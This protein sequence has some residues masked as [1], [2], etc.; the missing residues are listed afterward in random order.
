MA[1]WLGTHGLAIVAIFLFVAI[2]APL[3]A[4]Q[5]PYD[6]ANLSLS[7]ARRPPGYV[8]EGGYTHWLGTD[9]QG[10]DMLVSAQTGS[11]KTVAFGL[12]IATGEMSRLAVWIL[13]A[14][15]WLARLG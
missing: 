7:D 9:A 13:E 3:V 2:F 1:S 10:R 6:L 11:G 8:G 15:P 4:P 12:A 5:N 14:F